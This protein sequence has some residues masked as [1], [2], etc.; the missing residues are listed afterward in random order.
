M[1]IPDVILVD[2]VPYSFDYNLNDIAYKE[3]KHV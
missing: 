3:N 2:S 1:V